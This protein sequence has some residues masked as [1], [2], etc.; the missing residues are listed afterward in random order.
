M[1]RNIEK[2]WS[3][4]FLRTV[5]CLMVIFYHV[6]QGSL[7]PYTQSSL[8]YKKLSIACAN[9][10][11]VV[12]CFFII[13]GYFLMGF[14]RNKP[15]A[16]FLPFLWGKICR[17]WPV[18]LVSTIVTHFMTHGIWQDTF[19]NALFL[20]LTG[21]TFSFRGINWYVSSLFCSLV[22][23][24]LVAKSIG[25]QYRRNFVILL[26]CWGAYV[27]NMQSHPPQGFGRE[28]VHGFFSLGLLRGIAGVG[29]GILLNEFV[30]AIRGK[31]STRPTLQFVILMTVVEAFSLWLLIEHL[32]MRGLSCKSHFILVVAF[33][34][35]LPC[36]VLKFGLVSR[37]LNQK[38]LGC[39]G[40]YTYS[41]YVMQQTGFWILQQT[42]WIRADFVSE[43]MVPCLIVSVVI[44]A[45]IGILAYY[46]IEV[47]GRKLLECVERMS[48][49]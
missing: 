18:F 10:G 23:Y 26:C 17:L 3:V 7:I 36:L 27:L 22:F 38:W 48:Q 42:I 46:C 1:K 44:P 47:P 9:M 24:F 15:N 20:Q 13:S 40:K 12:E 28:I 34:A 41:M 11:F 33:S 14:L 43:H 4:E 5:F 35:L 49:R 25:L 32:F 29:W 31:I 21:L 6:T 2:I 16:E 39:F 19:I 8:A 30:H 37:A 45:A